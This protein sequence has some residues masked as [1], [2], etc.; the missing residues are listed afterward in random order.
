MGKTLDIYP[1]VYT[2]YFNILYM[3]LPLYL[4]V[5]QA[6][7]ISCFSLESMNVRHHVEHLRVRR[8][9][10]IEGNS[11][12]WSTRLWKSLFDFGKR[13]AVGP[14]ENIKVVIC[15]H[16]RKYKIL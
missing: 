2:E 11:K 14:C 15:Q 8:K 6:F 9:T 5:F 12:K 3:C 13:L 4:L 1:S 16:L 10:A 7:L